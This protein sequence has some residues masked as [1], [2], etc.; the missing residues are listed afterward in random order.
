MTVHYQATTDKS[1]V[2]AEHRRAQTIS[3]SGSDDLEAVIVA[4][5][6]VVKH[7]LQ[8]RLNHKL[9]VLN[10]QLEHLG[11]FIFDA[12]NSEILFYRKIDSTTPSGLI[13]R[14]PVFMSLLY[15]AAK[16][17]GTHPDVFTSQV[18]ACIT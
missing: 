2:I 4:W 12:K 8:Q 14:F 11:R 18:H 6:C 10:R 9:H 16:A 7:E 1:H 17:A 13:V 3:V 5:P 15:E